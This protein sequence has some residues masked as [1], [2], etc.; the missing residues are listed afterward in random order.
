VEVEFKGAVQAGLGDRPLS[1]LIHCL[2]CQHWAGCGLEEASA[3]YPLGVPLVA[4][5]NE[6][7]TLIAIVCEACGAR[8]LLPPRAVIDRLKRAG[9]GDG[10]TGVLELGKRVRGPCRQCRATRFRSE[11]IR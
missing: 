10:S 9:T 6:E 11:I 4:F 8:V 1:H 7:D 5:L 2:R 3:V